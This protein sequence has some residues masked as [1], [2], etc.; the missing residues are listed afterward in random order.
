M[1]EREYAF[2]RLAHAIQD[3]I[4]V[5]AIANQT[6]SWYQARHRPLNLYLR[7]P[8]GLAVSVGLGVAL[9]HP[10]RDVV[11]IEGDGGLLM[12]LTALAAVAHRQP[13]NLKLI[14]MDN[15]IYEAGGKGPTLNA[16]RM[17]MVHTAQGMGIHRAASVDQP[18][19]LDSTI[20]E[21]LHC[22]ECSFLHVRVG[23]RSGPMNAPKTKPYEMKHHFLSAVRATGG[24]TKP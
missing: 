18:S 24:S 15:G 22:G 6:A 14:C 16:A 5:T 9:A 12:G 21:W 23:M 10:L 19:S 8:M 17:D 3:Q 13:A 1:I 7:G 4:V 2:S 11:V 20:A